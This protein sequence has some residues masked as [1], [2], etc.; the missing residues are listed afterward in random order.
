MEDR[1]RTLWTGPF[2]LRR[3][4]RPAFAGRRISSRRKPVPE[5]RFSLSSPRKNAIIKI[6]PQTALKSGFRERPFGQE[7]PCMSNY[8]ISISR[9]FGSGGRMI[10]K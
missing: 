2:L 8:V 4:G 3:A 7:V 6:D 9:E 10:G 5:R 1:S